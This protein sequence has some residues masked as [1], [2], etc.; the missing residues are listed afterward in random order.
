MDQEIWKDIIGYEGLYQVSNFGR[1]KS[2]RQNRIM[3]SSPNEK[4]YLKIGLTKGKEYKT[5]KVHRLVAQAF[6]PNPENKLEINHINHIRNDN[7]VENLEWITRK[8]NMQGVKG[9]GCK[10]NN[11]KRIALFVDGIKVAEYKS[12]SQ[13]SKITGI[14]YEAL[15][16]VLNPKNEKLKWKLI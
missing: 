9:G 12:I 6:I 3:K 15:R 10:G 1:I 8:D 7:R 16:Y 4:G 2:L 5:K 11:D 13:A 14:D